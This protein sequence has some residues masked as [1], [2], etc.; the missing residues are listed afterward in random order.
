M[1]LSIVGS[2]RVVEGKGGVNAAMGAPTGMLQ[3]L[4][5]VSRVLMIIVASN[6][7]ICLS[8]VCVICCGF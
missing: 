2:P 1:P 8:L 4:A 7:G 3:L 6:T 5:S